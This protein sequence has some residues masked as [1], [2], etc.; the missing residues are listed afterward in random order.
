[1]K[2]DISMKYNRRIF[3][4]YKG[5]GWDPLFY[6]AI[7]FLFLTQVKGIEPAKVMYA[8][9]AYAIFV[10]VFQ[11]PITILI[12]KI[13]SRKSLIIGC[14]LE[15]MQVVMMIFANSFSILI[16]A[17][18]L[19]AFGKSIKETAQSALLYDSTKVCKGKNS[20]GSLDAKGSALSY[21]LGAITSVLAGYLYVINPYIPI[22]LS[23]SLSFITVIIAYRFEEVEVDAESDE[24]NTIAESLNS[25]K[26]GFK[27]IVKSKRLRALFLFIAIFGGLL[28]TLSTY[29]KGLL[30]DIQVPSQYFGIIFALL[31]LVQCFSVKY[32]DKIHNIFRNRTLTFISIPICISLIVVGAVTTISPNNVIVIVTIILAF[33]VQHFL[34]APYWVL[35]NR[36]VTNFTN[37]DNRAKVLSSARLVYGFGRIVITFLAGLLLEYYC[38]S[39]A[40]IV[41]G[42]VSLVLI[43]LTLTYMNSRIGLSPEKYDKSD[44]EYIKGSNL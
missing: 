21:I 42:I 22:I 34:R 29:E 28:M 30:K 19:S 39:Q 10:L 44:I 13:G 33:F 23:S 35:E 1:M 38:T 6:S 4:I 8:E 41:L 11:M 25:M 43:L 15:T 5:L 9:S 37:D 40:Y 20:F 16:F 32:Q 7:I 24:G 14:I 27:F 17:Y 31:T 2:K 18:S 12:E 36:Y 26:Q 3:P